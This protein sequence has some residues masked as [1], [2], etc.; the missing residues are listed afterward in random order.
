[1]CGRFALSITPAD[2]ANVFRTVGA[3]PNVEPTWNMAPSQAAP[4]VRRQPKTGERHLDLL[5]WGMLP[6]FERDPRAARKP[7]NARAETVA[8]LPTFRGAFAS[9]R[10]LVPAE[11]FYEWKRDGKLKQP[12]A[13]GRADGA[14]LAFGGLWESWTDPA[15][16]Q[17]T[18]T[19]CI[20][21]TDANATMAPIHNRMPV[22]LEPEDW[23]VWLGEADGDPAALLRPAADQVLRVWPVS[24][25]V[26]N[27]R[28]N[29]PG[30]LAPMREE[31]ESGG[32][33]P[34]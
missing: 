24:T 27:V 32:P 26:N 6:H 19:F 15:S 22:V 21:T 31:A 13:I 18:R 30:L 11:A 17:V 28:H 34:A 16:G 4:V 33:N 7:T 8:R 25:E 12:F 20:V 10:C 2:I 9:R 14:P 23:P 29:G 1:M 3:L 5:Q